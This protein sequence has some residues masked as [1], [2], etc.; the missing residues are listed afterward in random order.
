MLMRLWLRLNAHQLVAIIE[1][2]AQH[3][4][5]KDA[6]NELILLI[7]RQFRPQPFLF[8]IP[9][10]LDYLPLETFP[11]LVSLGG[12]EVSARSFQAQVELAFL[13]ADGGSKRLGRSHERLIVGGSD[14]DEAI[15]GGAHPYMR[16]TR[17]KM[18]H[19]SSRR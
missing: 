14:R 16:S 19:M 13:M 9:I 5:H 18:S 12:G 8:G 3:R 4:R 6:A 11:G 10:R 1:E 17:V 7:N 15:Q 2:S